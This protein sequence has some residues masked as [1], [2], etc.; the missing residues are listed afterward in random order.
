ME[1]T[2]KRP[3]MAYTADAAMTTE[4]KHEKT[5]EAFRAYYTAQ[6]LCSVT[7]WEETL[8]LL[9]RPL[10]LSVRVNEAVAADKGGIDTATAPLRS[11]LS[12][13]LQ[14]IP[15]LPAAFIVSG[16]EGIAQGED[17]CC[18]P[19]PPPPPPA[20]ADTCAEAG[21]E[22]T[23]EQAVQHALFLGMKSG[24]LAQQEVTS[25]V[26]A[27]LLAPEPHHRVLDMCAAPGS[28][29]S[30]VLDMMGPDATGLL[31]VNERD[32]ARMRRLASRM[33]RHLPVAAPLQDPGVRSRVPPGLPVVRRCLPKR[34]HDGQA[35]R[36]QGREGRGHTSH[37]LTTSACSS[38]SPS[39]EEEPGLVWGGILEGRARSDREAK[40]GGR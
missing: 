37:T 12:D 2:T 25:M 27:L 16:G 23:L 31:I 15:W 32:T 38:D 21:G 13:S 20:A 33:L 26:P 19:P 30:Q 40:G 4:E 18:V 24:E 5:P 35:W 34:E 1:P 36:A 14:P 39:N 9:H 17:D 11:L 22:F 3:R 6:R 29:T 28:K 7:A 10:L 8:R